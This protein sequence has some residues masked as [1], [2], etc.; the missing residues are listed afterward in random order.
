MQAESGEQFDGDEGVPGPRD[1]DGER[2]ATQPGGGTVGGGEERQPEPA[3]DRGEGADVAG[4]PQRVAGDEPVGEH[5]VR[6][7]QGRV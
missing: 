2:A 5:V 7:R 3:V 4:A 1:V 6:T